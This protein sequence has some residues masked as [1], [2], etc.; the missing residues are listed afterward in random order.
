MIRTLSRCLAALFLISAAMLPARAE[1]SP[2][3][4][5]WGNVARAAAQNDANQVR[6]MIASGSNPNEVDENNRTGMHIAAM[7]GNLQIMAILVKGNAKS[8]PRDKLGNTPLHYATDRDRLEAVKLLLDLKAPVDAENKQ[9]MTALMMAAARGNL[10]IV[11]ALLSHGASPTKADFTGR[12]AAGW[13]LESKK[14]AVAQAIK[15]AAL[16]TKR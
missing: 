16:T 13:A 11:Q 2:F 8:D 5:Y 6:Q 14:P 7:N 4:S 3:G 9:G 1:W 10:E 15:R 12:D